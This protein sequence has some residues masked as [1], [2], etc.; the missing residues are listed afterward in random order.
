M[1]GG[2]AIDVYDVNQ[3]QSVRQ[4]GFRN[5]KVDAYVGTDQNRNH[6]S[7]KDWYYS[8]LHRTLLREYC[9]QHDF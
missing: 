8:D 1:V 7:G 3:N 6:L 5:P 4:I 9:K 2:L